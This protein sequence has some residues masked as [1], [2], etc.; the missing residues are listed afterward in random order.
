MRRGIPVDLCVS[1]LMQRLDKMEQRVHFDFILSSL[2]SVTICGALKSIA[3]GVLVMLYVKLLW[4]RS[5]EEYNEDT[6]RCTR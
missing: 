6:Q 5:S 2:G 3:C 1:D 4:A